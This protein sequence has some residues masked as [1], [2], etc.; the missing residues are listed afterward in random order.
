MQQKQVLKILLNIVLILAGVLTV[1]PFIWMVCSSFKTNAEIS[2]LDQSLFPKEPTL[3][4]YLSLQENFDFLTYFF[5]SICITLAITA[6]V[7]YTS[8]VCGYVLSK[9]EFKGK[10][11][12][13]GTVLMTMM[14][15][16]AVTIIPRYTMFQAAGLYDSYVSLVLPVMISGFGILML[17]QGID[18]LPNE[19]L[20]AAR[21]DGANEFY[22]V[23]RIVFPLSRNSISAIAIFQFLW[24]WEDY[25]WPYLMIDSPEK[26]LLAVGLTQFNGRFTTDYGG[27]FA[28]TA[29]SII[30]VL[31]IYI[32]FQKRFV[33]GIAN[34]AVKG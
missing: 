31:I 13:F 15:P 22:I 27:L 30:P 8:T 1:I 11:I 28:A 24:C 23:H 6:L 12:L 2:A 7:I 16:W 32:I 14:I 10:K 4:N 20:E 34:S 5:N 33:V 9:Y 21:M 3:I 18:T 19:L 26:Q 25:L 29:I 17:K